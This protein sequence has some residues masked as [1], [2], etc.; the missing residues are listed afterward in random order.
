MANVQTD[1]LRVLL[2]TLME[3]ELIGKTTYDGAVRLVNGH[4][5]FP[6]FFRASGCCRGEAQ[7]HGRSQSP[8]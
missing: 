2:D 6:E 3:M 7:S 5:D 4:L 1:V 8:N